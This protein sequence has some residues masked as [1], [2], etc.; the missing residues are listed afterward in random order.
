[1]ISRLNFL[2]AVAMLTTLVLYVLGR[3]VLLNMLTL[4]APG[5]KPWFAGALVLVALMLIVLVLAQTVSRLGA[6]SQ[7]ARAHATSSRALLAQ[8]TLVLAHLCALGLIHAIFDSTVAD[9]HRWLLWAVTPP[10][11][12]AGL[13]LSIS[14]WKARAGTGR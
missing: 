5:W 9:A 1:M 3:H 12:A 2:F 7:G 4:V 8:A 13:A 11:Y 6:L 14:G 10:L